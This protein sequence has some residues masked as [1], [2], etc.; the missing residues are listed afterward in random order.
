[1]LFNIKISLKELKAIKS[2][3]SIIKK[4]SILTRKKITKRK[5]NIIHEL[6]SILNKA[7]EDDNIC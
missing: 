5:I 7:Q 3:I 1:M 6:S 4:Q 2:A